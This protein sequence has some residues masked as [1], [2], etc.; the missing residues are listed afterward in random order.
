METFYGVQTDTRLQTA[1][2]HHSRTV[3]CQM[4]FQLVNN[5]S[6]YRRRQ[7]I[8]LEETKVVIGCKQVVGAAQ[9]E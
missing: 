4:K 8:Q 7:Y 1:E 3:G 6:G 5:H 2:T 9:L